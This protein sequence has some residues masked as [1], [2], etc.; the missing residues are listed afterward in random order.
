M[1]PT[2]TKHQMLIEYANKRKDK[3]ETFMIK[4]YGSE[5]TFRKT[6]D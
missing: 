5:D 6:V 1:L 2:S 4:K 3:Y